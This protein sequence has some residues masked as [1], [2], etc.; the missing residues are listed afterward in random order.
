MLVLDISDGLLEKIVLNRSG[1]FTDT[2]PPLGTR[3]RQTQP[4]L[5]IPVFKYVTGVEITESFCLSLG[6][7][8]KKYACPP[9]FLPV[10][11]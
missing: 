11:D 3:L 2:G 9:L 10:N 4:Y 6:K 7:V 8:S 5:D 1:P